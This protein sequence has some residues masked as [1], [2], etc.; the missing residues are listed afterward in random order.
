MWF[1]ASTCGSGKYPSG[2]IIKYIWSLSLAPSTELLKPWVEFPEG[3]ECLLS[4]LM[5]PLRTNA[6]VPAN[7]VIRVELHVSVM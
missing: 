1:Q 2:T 7:E 3:K 4:F 5:I 6:R